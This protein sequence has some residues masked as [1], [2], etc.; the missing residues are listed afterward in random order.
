MWR[1]DA[2]RR[3]SSDQQLGDALHLQWVR[4]LPSLTVAWPDQEMM[5]FDRQYEPIVVGR[6]MFVGSSQADSLTAYDTRDGS[7]LWEFRAEG[8]IR[9]APAAAGDKLFCT[10]DDGYLY[11]L[12]QADGSLLWKHR[13]G[14]SDRKVLGNERMISLWPARGGPVVADGTV[15]YAA[16]IWPFMGIFLHA[17]DAETGEVRWTNDGEGSRFTIQPHNTPSFAGVAPQGALVVDGDRLIVPGGRSIPACYDRR[18]GRLLHYHLGANNKKGGGSDVAAGAGLFFNGG[19]AFLSAEGHFVEGYASPSLPVVEG[20]RAWY[21]SGDDL[22]ELEFGEPLVEVRDGKDRK[23]KPIKTHKLRATAV[24]SDEL[25]PV[26]EEAPPGDLI[27]AG[28]RLFGCSGNRVFS[29]ETTARSEK[30]QTTWESTIEGTAVRLLAADDRLFV[31]TLE[32]SIFCFGSGK[33]SAPVVHDRPLS[34]PKIDDVV[35][36]KAQKI[37]ELTGA[38]AGHTVVWGA[39]DGSL[40]HALLAHSEL[41]LI[42]VEPEAARAGVLR[43]SLVEAGLYGRRAAVF[44]GDSGSLQ[45]PP[46]F[47]SSMIAENASAGAIRPE[48]G[49]LERM[50]QSLRPYGGVAWFDGT[51]ASGEPFMKALGAAK[52]PGAGDLDL[53]NF[54][55]VVVRRGPIEGSADWTH[56]HADASNTRTS[57]DKLVKLPLGILWFGGPSHEK[58]LPR[59]GH[60]PQPQVVEGRVIIEGPD[61]LRA[62][63]VYTGRLLWE[64]ELPG[65]G[66]LYNN[67]A[68]HPGANGTG[69]NYISLPDGIYAI[70]PPGCVRL[71]PQTGRTMAT[72]SLPAAAPVTTAAP[73]TASA[74][75]AAPPAWNYVNVVDDYLVASIDLPDSLA[76]PKRAY[77]DV[78]AGKRIYVL[79]RHDGRVLWSYDAR[80][81][82]RNNAICLGG[83]RLYC[84]DLLS[85][86]EQA[87]LKR[88]GLKAKE[89]S[90][91]TALDLATG[92]VLWST[93]QNVFGTWLSYSQAH[94]ILVESGRPGRDVLKDEPKGMRAYDA[95]TGRV[96]WNSEHSGPAILHG[97]RIIADKYLCDLRTGKLIERTDPLSGKT[98]DWI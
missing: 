22:K 15:Y 77:E 43:T 27:R 57:R 62:T 54:G 69:A 44:V 86:A 72:F 92:R 70:Y 90:K 3:A 20:R 60:G 45:L 87:L 75:N 42:V 17:L 96:L 82:F 14:P 46:Y 80:F 41:S 37:L 78:I 51:G 5:W 85:S 67:T 28:D 24:R 58:I 59:H 2:A 63:D 19:Q 12:A 98:V 83:G 93:D 91:L 7:Q 34:I 95:A 76:G 65:I 16:G 33:S 31:I 94:G 49:D 74:D 64:R 4:K 47:A 53:P 52:L 32:G 8:P 13:G 89:P 50:Y 81:Q 61:L 88:R 79:N 97:D 9:F 48:A 71:D 56:E 30:P 26:V 55:L 6:R 21:A 73:T 40:V 11:C 29:C 25:L 39:G 10:S 35:K 18:T 23:G 84:V 1:N 38:R 36:A 68:H 66:A